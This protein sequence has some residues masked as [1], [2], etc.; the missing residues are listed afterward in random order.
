MPWDSFLQTNSKKNVPINLGI[1]D[2]VEFIADKKDAKIR[3]TLRQLRNICDYVTV[4][5][6]STA[7]DLLWSCFR[8]STLIN[9][10]I[11]GF[12]QR[13]LVEDLVVNH[14]LYEFKE[15]LNDKESLECLNSIYQQNL[16]MIKE[17]K[18]NEF[19]NRCVTWL[20]IF[21]FVCVKR[22]GAERRPVVVEDPIIFFDLEKKI[23]YCYD[24]SETSCEIVIATE[25]QNIQPCSD[26]TKLLK[27]YKMHQLVEESMMRC[28][29]T[30]SQPKILVTDE[31]DPL[32]KSANVKEDKQKGD[33]EVL[34]E[35]SKLSSKFSDV[36]ISRE[37]KILQTAS[38][39]SHSHQNIDN[40]VL[41][42]QFE[43]TLV[44]KENTEKMI[45]EIKKDLRKKAFLEQQNIKRKEGEEMLRIQ[46][47]LQ[48]KGELVQRYAHLF[49]HVEGLQIFEV[50]VGK[51][52]VANRLSVPLNQGNFNL[53]QKNYNLLV[54]NV[55]YGRDICNVVSNA[56]SNS[57]TKKERVREPGL[58]SDKSLENKKV[59]FFYEL[60]MPLIEDMKIRGLYLS[61]I[62]IPSFPREFAPVETN[63]FNFKLINWVQYRINPFSLESCAGLEKTPPLPLHQSNVESCSGEP[64]AKKKKKNSR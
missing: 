49:S 14:L 40:S 22:V 32:E 18:L 58:G 53:F 21:G 9:T 29:N 2:A 27:A 46:K 13:F 1:D 25:P 43:R 8:T 60:I 64:K 28:W 17:Y 57:G 26:V 24:E 51:K 10:T 56:S 47:S 61:N 63:A 33:N 5:Y 16:T 42:S 15:E 38:G 35:F 30:A 4:F 62:P 52:V 37:S 6:P 59:F 7:T 48:N 54:E 39:L 55:I 50:P 41:L 36:L 19:M 23:Y 31:D 34:R 44:E 11:R 45:R 20:V 3:N 12:A